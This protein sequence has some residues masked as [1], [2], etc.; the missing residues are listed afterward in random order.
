MTRIAF[1]NPNATE[2]MTQ[3]C[4]AA[5][6]TYLPDGYEAVAITNEMGPPAIQGH[7]DGEAAIPGLLEIIAKSDYDAYIIACFDDTGLEQARQITKSPVI[8][9]GQAS[10]HYA[11]LRSGRFNVLTTLAVSI[12]VI[13]ENIGNQGFSGVCNGV[14]ASGVPVL[15]LEHNPDASRQIVASHIQRLTKKEPD[16]AVIL[17]CAGMTNIWQKLQAD[18]ATPLVDPV[19][20]AAKVIVPLL[21]D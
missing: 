1:I 3:T 11:A 8:G 20:A 21:A 2:V 18:F 17:G 14:Y 4:H 6:A 19:A 13:S 15:E 7:K 9:I 10:F 12:P 16:I 5:F